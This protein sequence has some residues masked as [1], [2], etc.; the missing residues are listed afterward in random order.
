MK[1]ESGNPYRP[2]LCFTEWANEPTRVD[3][4][5]AL[6]VVMNAT[7]WARIPQG[8]G[9]SCKL[10]YDG[11]SDRWPRPKAEAHQADRPCIA[12]TWGLKLICQGTGYCTPATS[13]QP[14]A[15]KCQAE[16]KKVRIGFYWAL[17]WAWFMFNSDRGLMLSHLQR[18][19][20]PKWTCSNLN[21]CRFHER[22]GRAAWYDD[23]LLSHLGGG[24]ECWW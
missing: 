19:L 5:L 21:S 9:L 24:Q 6:G 16:E 8:C 15:K 3:R 23:M 7:Y 12:V 14:A 1:N 2:A 11:C 13:S 4:I 20:E 17:L 22:I 18:M 10:P